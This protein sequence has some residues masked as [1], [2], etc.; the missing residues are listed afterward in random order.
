MSEKLDPALERVYHDLVLTLRE[1]QRII[2]GNCEEKCKLEIE[3]LD[4]EMQDFCLQVNKKIEQISR[5]L[6][7]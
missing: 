4:N 2:E 7:E 1:M 3:K 5:I 6:K